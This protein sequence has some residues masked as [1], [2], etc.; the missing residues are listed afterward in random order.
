[1]KRL[2]IALIFVSQAALAACPFGEDTNSL[3]QMAK[4]GAL[5]KLATVSPKKQSLK[6]FEIGMIQSVILAQD[7]SVPMTPKEALDVFNDVEYG[8]FSAGQIIY[9]TAK[10]PSVRYALVTYYPGENEYGA[11]FKVE[12]LEGSLDI[13]K[14]ADVQDSWITN[15]GLE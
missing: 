2:F 4:V 12:D 10:K 9:F 3:N 15:C 1:M 8:G 6:S 7:L 13:R 5:K 14:I 11:I